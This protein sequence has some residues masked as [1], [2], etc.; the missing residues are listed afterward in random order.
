[1]SN[2]GNTGYKYTY[3]SSN[4]LIGVTFEDNTRL[5]YEYDPAGNM[6]SHNKITA[7]CSPLGFSKLFEEYEHL[8]K[9]Y[10]KGE[11]SHSDFLEQLYN[12]RIQDERGTWWQ[13]GENGEWLKWDGAQWVKSGP[14]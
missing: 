11:L 9:T 13:I 4:R 14:E 10:Q 6:I 2:Q 1:M 8:K 3:D 12:L 7:D 5:I